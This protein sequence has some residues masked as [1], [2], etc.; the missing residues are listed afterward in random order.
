[1]KKNLRNKKR[2]YR[3]KCGIENGKREIFWCKFLKILFPFLFFLQLKPFERYFIK[4]LLHGIQLTHVQ[5][6]TEVQL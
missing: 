3:G 5:R 2:G 1:M 4:I 6:Y